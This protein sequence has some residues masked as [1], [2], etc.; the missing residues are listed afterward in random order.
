MGE[1]KA[2][3]TAAG[4]TA[5]GDAALQAGQ[6]A[7]KVWDLPVRLFHWL[8][9][10]LFLFMFFSGKTKGNWMEWHMYAGYAILALV[11]FRVLWGFAGSTHARFASFLAG[12]GRSF[13]FARKL[14]SREPAQVAGHNPLGGWMVVVLLGALLLQAG[15]GLFAN[16][17]ISL[18]GP[19][20]RLVSKEMSDRLTTIHYYNFY[21]LLG[22]AA[23]HVLAVLFHVFVKKEN[24]VSAMFTGEKKLDAATEVPAAR[25]AS[26]WLALTLLVLALAAVYLIVKRPF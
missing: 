24:L 6:R 16:D 7:V 25:F 1:H 8:L 22:L 14:L 15:C 2:G 11:L 20:S 17:D 5:V 13:A 9:V 18:E 12:P 19:L 26:S 23:V 21:V 4:K 3:K 10:A